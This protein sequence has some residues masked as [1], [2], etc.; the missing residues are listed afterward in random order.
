MSYDENNVFA[1]ILR[2]ELPSYK[3][4]ET[5]HVLV[6]MDVM[7]RSAGHMLVIPKA[8]ARNILDIG[9]G[10]LQHVFS[11][12]QLMSRLAKEALGADGVS[13]IQSNEGAGGQIVF[14][15]HVH[16]IPRWNGIELKPHSGVME[17][18][19]VLAS[20]AERYREALSRLKG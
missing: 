13:I 18:A 2:G 7:P 5:E 15:M 14:H 6:F 19:E 1:R 16:V 20:T 10:E 4:Y 17:D 12:V 8:K 11:A 3:V 9:Q